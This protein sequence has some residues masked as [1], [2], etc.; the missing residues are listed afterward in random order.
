[1]AQEIKFPRLNSVIVSGHLTRDVELRY[2]PKGTPVAKIGI[3]FNRVYKNAEGTWTEESNFLDVSS[4]GKQAELCSERLHKGSP[5][6][7]EGY[8]KTSFY[9]D[10]ENQQRKFVEI[11]ATKFHFLE[12]SESTYEGSPS[13]EPAKGYNVEDNDQNVTDD[14]VPF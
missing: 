8:I 11:V 9:N 14:D 2:T 10:K 7:I 4:W 3:A 13:S 12:K 1:M 5:V 6:I